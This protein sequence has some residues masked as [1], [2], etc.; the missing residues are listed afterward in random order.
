MSAPRIVLSAELSDA[1]TVAVWAS[2][3]LNAETFQELNDYLR[4]YAS[5]L[6][7]RAAVTAPEPAK[8]GGQ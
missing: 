2:G 7:K 4:V 6:A 5:V 1:T 3:P 8:D